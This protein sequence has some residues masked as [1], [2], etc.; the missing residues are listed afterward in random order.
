MFKRVR[1]KSGGLCWHLI[2]RGAQKRV[3]SFACIF[4]VEI[5]SPPP[6]RV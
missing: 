6:S 2:H 5:N 1:E 4:E 3:L